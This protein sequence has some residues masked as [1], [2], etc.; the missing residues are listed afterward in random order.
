LGEI[1]DLDIS[2]TL[3][4]DSFDYMDIMGF[5][6]VATDW[7]VESWNWDKDP[8]FTGNSLYVIEIHSLT[9]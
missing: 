2:G 3:F 1:D 6:T 5:G 4:A 7:S 9:T 8:D